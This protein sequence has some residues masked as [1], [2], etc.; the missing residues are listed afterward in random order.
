MGL[1][2]DIGDGPVGLDAS[3]FIYFMEEN[4]DFLSVVEP[5]FSAI[6]EEQLEAATSS[7]TLLEALVLPLRTGNLEI[8]RSY[9]E[10]LTRS[11][12]LKLISLDLGVLRAAAHLRAVTRLKTPDSLQIASAIIAGCPVFVTNDHRIPSLPGIRVL[13]LENYLPRNG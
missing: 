10:L 2:T 8:A 6:D 1:L 4:P 7:L 9:E 11:R 13:Q 3:I 12:G 5:V